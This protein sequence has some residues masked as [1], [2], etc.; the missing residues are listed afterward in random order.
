MIIHKPSFSANLA[1]SKVPAYLVL[2]VCAV[3]APLSKAVVS[4]ASHPRL[5]GVPFFQDAL[6]LMLDNSGRLLCEPTVCTAQAFCLLEMHKIAAS[7]SWTHH[8]RYFGA[9]S[10]ANPPSRRHPLVKINSPLT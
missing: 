10:C 2:A 4:K 3:A 1:L 9:S 8:F 6:N 5:A 7:H